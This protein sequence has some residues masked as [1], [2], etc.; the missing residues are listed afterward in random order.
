MHAEPLEQIIRRYADMVYRLALAH[1]REPAD[2]QDAFQDV[3]LRYAEKAPAFRDEE[4]R[5]AWLLRVT[6]NRCRSH[7]RTAWFRR[8]APMEAAANAAAPMPETNPLADVLSRLPAGYRTV[9][10]LHYYEELSTREIAAI[11]GQRP[12]TVRSQLTRAR[13]MLRELLKG[14]YDDV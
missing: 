1:L 12:S 11:T 5:R 8:T 4:H 13:S 14:E 6:V 2:A 7:Y 10:H 3:F 9:V